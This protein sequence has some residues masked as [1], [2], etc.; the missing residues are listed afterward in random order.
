MPITLI[1]RN[2]ICDGLRERNTNWSG[3]LSQL[4]FLSRLYRL[5]ELPSHDSRYSNAAADIMCHT[6]T[7]PGDWENL[8]IFEDQRFELPWN[9]ERLLAFLAEMLHPAVRPDTDEVQELVNF[10]NSHLTKDGW[11]LVEI[12]RISDRP[13]FKASQTG[14]VNPI[15]PMV[16]V[17]DSAYVSGRSHV[18]ARISTRTQNSQSGRRRS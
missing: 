14:H 12:E 8:W 11:H 5:N 17:L 2:A 1:T 10:L 9:D 13:I 15:V 18:P 6:V 3:R 4:E 7:W 16:D